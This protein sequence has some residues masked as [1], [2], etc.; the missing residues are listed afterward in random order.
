[1]NKEIKN[2]L[3][4]LKEQKDKSF[5]SDWVNAHHMLADRGV[6]F[7]DINDDMV[8]ELILSN[9]INYNQYSNRHKQ[10]INE[11]WNVPMCTHK[12]LFTNKKFKYE[13]LVPIVLASKKNPTSIEPYRYIYVEGVMEV[14]GK[15]YNGS[16]INKKIK[17]LVDNSNGTIT[18]E[19][20]NGKLVYK[21]YHSIE[22]KYYTTVPSDMLDFVSKVGNTGLIKLY[23]L[24][25]YELKNGSK[26]LSMQYM[27]DRIN[28][29]SRTTMDSLIKSLVLQGYITR[30]KKPLY[31]N[32]ERP[33]QE[34]EYTLVDRDEWLEKVKKA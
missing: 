1:M 26:Q 4:G 19:V 12:D 15:M 31:V 18:K 11:I 10:Y 34:Y 14:L 2:Y 23:L 13:D 24:L 9:P 21:I 8:L 5:M 17:A 22:D 30:E 27:C 29:K 3:L 16:T 20:V 28:I 7:D 6:L 25:T 32:T 33:T